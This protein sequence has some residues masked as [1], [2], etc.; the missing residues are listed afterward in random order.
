MAPH[1]NRSSAG[2]KA[3]RP[4]KPAKP[5]P[6]FPLYAH[7]VG[8]WAKKVRGKIVYF[9]KWTEDPKGVT[10]LEQWLEQKDDLLAGRTPRSSSGEFV[11]RDLLN[12]FL[13]SKRVSRVEVGEMTARSFAEYLGTCESIAATFGRTRR[14]DDLA[15]DDFEKLRK[16]L[17]KTNGPVRLVNQ[18]Q[19]VRSVF[20]YALQSGWIDRLPTFG[21][22]F[23]KPSR[24]VLR[25]ARKGAGPRLL[26]ATDLKRI[27]DALEGKE[28]QTGRKDKE[29]GEPETV[30]LAPNP[31]LRAMVLLGI[32]C[33]LGNTDCGRLQSRH[34]DLEQGVLDYPRPKT[35]VDRQC[36]LWPETV[37]ALKI[38]I[39]ARPMPKDKADRD[40][41][42]LTIHGNPWT[43]DARLIPS[44][45]SHA[46]D[47]PPKVKPPIDAICPAFKNILDV[48]GLKRP[49]IGFYTLRHVFQTIGSRTRDEQAVSAIM[50]HE[51]E[52]TRRFYLEEFDRT[53]LQ[54]VTDYVRAWL[55]PELAGRATEKQPQKKQRSKSKSRPEKP[56][57]TGPALRLFVG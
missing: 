53:R 1:F 52:H 42:F 33:G 3:A 54:G 56:T 16:T 4:G 45:D 17:A 9:T 37:S 34:L 44:E 28:V 22:A 36:P 51:D 6:D 11:V 21:P 8:R 47:A 32:N 29:T 30:T 10:A 57:T 35:A 40:L 5:R 26:E 39:A 38:A 25:T 41:V 13:E 19:R 24:K 20:N 15:A 18:I 50:G 55:W 14:V 48:L 2:G 27:L 7:A 46:K 43:R 31:A 23:R 49:R 12:L